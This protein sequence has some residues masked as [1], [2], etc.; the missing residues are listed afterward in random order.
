MEVMEVMMNEE[1]PKGI[2]L[3]IGKMSFHRFSKENLNN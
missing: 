2:T 1:V 3:V